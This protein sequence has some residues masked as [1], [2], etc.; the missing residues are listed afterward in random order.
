MR[1][2]FFLLLAFFFSFPL[3]AA[4]PPEPSYRIV[5]GK[6]EFPWNEGLNIFLEIDEKSCKE[7]YGQKWRQK[8][9]GAPG[10]PG[11]AAKGV[12]M[13]PEADGYWEWSDI[14]SLHFV[15]ANG[16]AI[17]PDTEYNID[18]SGLYLPPSIKLDKN[19]L[20]IFTQPL[21][22]RLRNLDFFINPAPEGAHRLVC[23]VEFNY[24]VKHDPEIK[25]LSSNLSFGKADKVWNGERDRLNISWPLRKLADAPEQC[26]ILFTGMGQVFLDKGI[27]KYFPPIKDKGGIIFTKNLPARNELFFIKSASLE[28]KSDSSLDSN[29]ILKLNS[30]LYANPKDLLESLLIYELPK[31]RSPEAKEVCNWQLAPGLSADI[32]KKSRKLEPVYVKKNDLPQSTLEFQIPVK[33]GAYILLAVD[34]KFKSAS[35]QKLIR[36]WLNILHAE[37]IN[38][39][40]GFLQ[41]GNVLSMRNGSTLDLFGRELES[42]AW[43]AQ[44]L[45]DPFL[46]LL[47]SSSWDPF[48]SPFS[49]LNAESSSFSASSKG[50]IP[51]KRIGQGKGQ[52]A[53][54]DLA[55]IVPGLREAAANDYSGG[56]LLIN[57]TGKKDGKDAAF[58][59]RLVLLSDLALIV[60]KYANGQLQAFVRDLANDKAASNLDIKVL[61]ANGIPVASA[62]T[63]AQGQ[64]LLPSLNGLEKECSPVAI[65]A[66]DSSQFSWLPL[67][68]CGRELNYSDFNVGGTHIG[69]NDLNIYVFSQRDIYRPGENM[70]FGCLARKGNLD[71]LPQDLPLYAEIQDPRGFVVWNKSITV[72]NPGLLS[73]SWTVPKEALSGRY[74][75]NIRTA[76]NGPVLQSKICRVEE[77]QPETLKLKLSPPLIDGWLE[78]KVNESRPQIDFALQNLYGTPAKGNKVK[79][80]VELFPAQFRFKGYENYIFCDARPGSVS[81]LKRQLPEMRT[82]N[83]GNCVVKLPSDLLGQSSALAVISAE[84]FNASGGRAVLAQTSLLTSPMSSIIGYRPKG[85]LTNF[86]YIPLNAK[87]GIHFIALNPK[88]EKISLEELDFS[89]SRSRLVQSLL[90]DGNGGYK[91]DENPLEE[92]IKKWT[93]NCSPTGLDLDLDTK[94]PGDYILRIKDKNGRLLSSIAYSVIGE[95][96]A[97]PNSSLQPSKM[98]IRLNKTTL[99]PGDIV[100]LDLSLPY[101]GFGLITLEREGVEA[102]QWFNAKAGESIHKFKIPEKFEGKGYLVINFARDPDSSRIYMSPLTYAIESV[103]VNPSK[104]DMNLKISAFDKVQPG[105]DLKI[106]MS[107]AQKG[108]AILFA[109]DEG[110]LQL[111]GYQN[112]NPLMALIGD[113]ALDVKTFQALDLLMPIQGLERRLSAFGGGMD[114]GA[115]GAR[116]QNPFKRKNEPPVVAWYFDLDVN[117]DGTEINLPIPDYYNGEIRIMA[118]ALSEKATG[119]ASAKCVVQAPFQINPQLP[120]FVA[121]GDSFKGKLLLSN[122]SEQEDEWQLSIVD[123]SDFNIVHTDSPRIKLGSGEERLWTFEVFTPEKLGNFELRFLADNG[124]RKVERSYNISI[125]PSSLL[126]TN[127]QAGIFNNGSGLPASPPMYT[128]K[129]SSTGTISTLPLALAQGLG[130]Y[131]SDYP[132]GCTEQLLSRSFAKLLLKPWLLES[133]KADQKLLEACLSAMRGRL[134]GNGLSLWPGGEGDLLLSAYGADFLLHLRMSGYV[135][136]D[137]LLTLLCDNLAENCA[138]NESTIEAARASAYAIWVLTREGRVTSQLIEELLQA[139]QERQIEGWENDLTA[140]LIAASQKELRFPKCLPVYNI[141][142]DGAGFFDEFAQYALQ[143]TLLNKYFPELLDSSKKEKF[144]DECA[145]VLNGNRYA[146]FSAAQA[147]RAISELAREGRKELIT[148]RIYCPD[149]EGETIEWANGNVKSEKNSFCPQYAISGDAEG[150]FWQISNTGYMKKAGSQTESPAIVIEKDF[151]DMNGNIINKASLGQEVQIRIRARSASGPI[152]DCVIADLLPGGL[153]MVFDSTG[154]GALPEAI[155]YIDRQEDRLLIFVDL[156]SNPLE[157]VCKTR[158]AS[159]GSFN[160]AP[161]YSEAM[162]NRY[163]SGQSSPG[164]LAVVNE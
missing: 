75:L 100:D 74:I 121:P 126:V 149:N 51:L 22:V 108:K 18:L 146:T 102:W 89:L 56:L 107:A 90:S 133:S 57:L 125:R 131:L 59:R 61:G 122:N 99:Q 65:I 69:P 161:A 77:F 147:I 134:S 40:V 36:P 138:I 54:L 10:R 132:Y 81:H 95:S 96:L 31:F 20:K 117:P 30:S 14:N 11:Y 9:A 160:I 106:K 116:F 164:T 73:L 136:A 119:S 86:Q 25:I 141:E 34:D 105:N 152:K 144:F 128:E 13:Q 142:Y 17:K 140:L 29:Y 42:I 94:E 137:D 43:E 24:P 5:S 162:Y 7:K 154:K 63:D 67:K 92:L 55:G 76:K 72:E 38:P 148:S 32:L 120:L 68:D 70:F 15:P 37:P 39:E 145:S 84:G 91:Y 45:R 79:A 27:I 85:D 44:L 101:D 58:A 23:E 50:E 60:K 64:A 114:G 88:L 46:A 12:I 123:A 1:I 48:S 111:T 66:S 53:S 130:Q 109:V 112:P 163:Q 135:Y 16:E 41:P 103:M 4:V 19:S 115:F 21:S 3:Y 129:A 153:E 93:G 124:K 83:K 159:E 80:I 35:G 118:V 2:T 156:D 62:K 71:V 78:I 113:R 157:Y 26:S 127:I 143:I 6:A 87:A 52:F 82:D 155:K 139:L 8:C 98:R 158:A 28:S 33:Q 49:A 104:R 97:L 150:L 47:A 110:I 151:L